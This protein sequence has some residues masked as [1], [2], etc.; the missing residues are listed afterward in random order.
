LDFFH[1]VISLSHNGHPRLLIKATW[2]FIT[3]NTGTNAFC[4]IGRSDDF[5]LN[6]P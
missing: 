4:G 3:S 2:F 5:P 6:D 1:L